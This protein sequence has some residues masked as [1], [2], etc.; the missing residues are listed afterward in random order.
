M[1]PDGSRHLITTTIVAGQ[2]YSLYVIPD[3]MV[4]SYYVNLVVGSYD[5]PSPSAI[6][7]TVLTDGDKQKDPQLAINKVVAEMNT[8]LAA[9]FGAHPSPVTWEEKFEAM[10]AALTFFFQGNVPQIK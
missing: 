2:L 8:A 6:H 4:N 1:L 9:Y 7:S 5:T 10:V 3:S